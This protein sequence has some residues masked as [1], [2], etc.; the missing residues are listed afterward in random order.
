MTNKFNEQELLELIEKNAPITEPLFLPNI[1][2]PRIPDEVFTIV[3]KANGE[4]FK[5]YLEA[6]KFLPWLDEVANNSINPEADIREKCI[7]RTQFYQQC[8][9]ALK[10][11]E[12]H[13]KDNNE[14]TGFTWINN[15]NP[16]SVSLQ[17]A[18][19]IKAS[20]VLSKVMA[21]AVQPRIVETVADL[22]DRDRQHDLKDIISGKDR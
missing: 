20:A 4:E 3:T 2:T 8:E 21:N 15:G 19:I 9:M 16:Y 5:R 12:G 6:D 18:N 22:Y 13:L 1:N 7:E 11:I 10:S 17:G 14:L